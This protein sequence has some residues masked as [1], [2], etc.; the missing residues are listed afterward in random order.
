MTFT[1]R[2]IVGGDIDGWL[3]LWKGYLDFYRETLDDEVTRHT[4]ERLSRQRDDVFGF[5]AQ[6]RA[7]ALVGIAHGLLH[8]STWSSSPSCY[9]EDLFV[10]PGARG[11][12]VAR[13]LVEAVA[14]EACRRGA[15]KL[16]WHTQEYN[17]PARS[18]YDQLATRV[19]FVVYERSLPET[20]TRQAPPPE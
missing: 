19:S 2:P 17:G 3:P 8:P 13:A 9:L 1:V 10:A 6:S 18:L 11:S 20:S 7:D 12:G 5:V 4:F 16:Y 15:V 14:E